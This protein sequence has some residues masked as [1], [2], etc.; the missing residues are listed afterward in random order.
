MDLNSVFIFSA[1]KEPNSRVS[2]EVFDKAKSGD[3][4]AFGQIYN[5]Y[6]Q[7]IYRFI[8]FRVSHKQVAEDLAE[9]VFLK[10]FGKIGSARGGDSF[11]GWL[12]QIARNMVIDYYREKKVDVALD[13]IENTLEYESNIVES[14]DLKQ[15]Q[16]LM[17]KLLKQLTS[18]QQMV[19]KLKFIE[20]LENATISELLHKTEGAIRVI[21][22]RAITK[23]QELVKQH[24]DNERK[25]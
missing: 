18:E 12:Y 7:K 1:L 2:D 15:D 19:V 24:L 23:L 9:E 10:V 5:L 25:F 21:Q 4:V 6:F 11:E 3:Q 17:L 16:Q 13:E 22:H 8:Y 20:D 14:V